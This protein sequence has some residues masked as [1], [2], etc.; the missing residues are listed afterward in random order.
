[1]SDDTNRPGQVALGWWRQNLR[2]DEDSGAARALRAR[3]RRSSDMV[4]LLSEP[5]VIALY[6]ALNRRP[7]PETLAA[8]VHVLSQV[9]RHDARRAAQVFGAGDP[10][11]LS[12]LRFQRLIRSNDPAELMQVLRRALPLV[13]HA[14]NVA[15]LAEDLLFWG[16]RVRVRWCF[17]YFG[18]RLPTA[19]GTEEN[20]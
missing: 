18:A 1:M 10:K 19:S 16:E 20:E 7:S 2:P 4:E 8:I 6:E 9:E 15:A 12:A 3:L 5:N 11:P 13:G 17:D 14:C